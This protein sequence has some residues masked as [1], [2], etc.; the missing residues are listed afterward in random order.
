M[1]RYKTVTYGT[2]AALLAL[3]TPA[4]AAEAPAQ[5]DFFSDTWRQVTDWVSPSV[6]ADSAPSSGAS[7]AQ[8]ITIKD[9]AVGVDAS[10]AATSVTVENDG[11]VVL[12]AAD[13][14]TSA[15]AAGAGSPEPEQKADTPTASEPSLWDDMLGSVGLSDEAPA[16]KQ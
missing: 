10:T 8:A 15:V 12:R 9:G 11:T 3:A 5:D 16:V 14:S 1:M 2:I 13:G 6:A 7:A 4:Y